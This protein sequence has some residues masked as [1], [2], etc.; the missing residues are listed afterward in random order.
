MDP[1]GVGPSPTPP[2]GAGGGGGERSCITVTR[3][4]FR[5]VVAAVEFA[6]RRVAKCCGCDTDEV[7]K[8]DKSYLGAETNKNQEVISCLV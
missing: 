2:E 8:R 4:G 7:P 5:F 6:L 3:G 1:F